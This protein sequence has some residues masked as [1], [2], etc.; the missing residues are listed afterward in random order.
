MYALTHNHTSTCHILQPRSGGPRVIYYNNDVFTLPASIIII[1]ICFHTRTASC[2]RQEINEPNG[3]HHEIA[4]GAIQR[5]FDMFTFKSRVNVSDK[6]E[7]IHCDTLHYVTERFSLRGHM[8]HI[9]RQ[10]QLT[11]FIKET[12]RGYTVSF[13]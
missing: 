6:Y 11:V 2:D 5:R 1:I 12:S 4:G 10:S 8:K 13:C 3:S 9:N 7:Y